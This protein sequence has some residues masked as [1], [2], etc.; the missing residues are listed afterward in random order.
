VTARRITVDLLAAH[1][2]ASVRGQLLYIPRHVNNAARWL[3]WDGKRATWRIISLD[4][5]R[6]LAQ[7]CI[8]KQRS[9]P[10]LTPRDVQ[11]LDAQDLPA[12]LVNALKLSPHVC[13]RVPNQT[14]A[15]TAPHCPGPKVG[16]R[17]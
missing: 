1:L 11:M 13:V 10:G 9:R 2:V 16:V 7:D 15:S 5:V 8:D 4:D 3:G 6:A 12:Q 17:E 14:Q